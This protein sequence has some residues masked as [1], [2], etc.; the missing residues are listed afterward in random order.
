MLGYWNKPEATADALKDGILHTGDAGSITERGELAISDRISLM[1]NRGGANVYP[2]EVER[3]VMSYA[4][5]DSCGV[6]GV[7]DERLGERV[8]VLVQAQPGAE[9]DP[10]GLVEHCRAQLAA[11]KAPE[12]VVAVEGLPRNAMGK[13]D[14][15]QLVEIGLGL[16]AGRE[17]IRSPPPPVLRSARSVRGSR[18]RSRRGRASSPRSSARAPRPSRARRC[19]PWSAP[20]TRSAARR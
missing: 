12:W 11:Y 20:R 1:L 16:V 10:V 14:R 8:A 2:A 5:V 15:R 3:V 17:R 13:V 6:F 9:V 7:P 19:R 18:A 4:A